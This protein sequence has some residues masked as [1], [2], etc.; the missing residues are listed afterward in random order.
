MVLKLDV[1]P[2]LLENPEACDDLQADTVRFA[3]ELLSV[4][5]EHGEDPDGQ[6][7]SVKG[8]LARFGASWVELWREAYRMVNRGG[9][10]MMDAY[11]KS[12]VALRRERLKRSVSEREREISLEPDEN[13]KLE[14]VHE[15]NRLRVQVQALLSGD[16]STPV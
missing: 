16:G 7:E 8:L 15:L 6:R 5:R 10:D 11:R 12:I 14:L 3:A 4:L 1:L 13:R 9:V 2:A